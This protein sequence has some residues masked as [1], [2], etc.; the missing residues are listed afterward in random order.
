[1]GDQTNGHFSRTRNIVRRNVE[2]VGQSGPE[3]RESSVVS[4]RLIYRKK[5]MNN[6]DIFARQ[7][8]RLLSTRSNGGGDQSV[9]QIYRF[10]GLDRPAIADDPAFLVLMAVALSPE[11]ALRYSISDSRPRWTHIQ[12]YLKQHTA[13]DERESEVLARRLSRILDDYGTKRARAAAYEA[14]IRK[15]GSACAICRLQFHTIPHAVRTR[16][17]YRPLW[18][19]PEELTSPEVDH[20]KPIGWTGNNSIANMQ[21]LCRACNAAKSDGIRISVHREALIAQLPRQDVPRMHFFRLLVW[22]VFDRKGRCDR[23]GRTHGELTMRLARP[24]A[25]LTRA[26]LWLVCYACLDSD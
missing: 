11:S 20:I 21:L 25:S 9:E 15:Q 26:N 3:H 6:M 23:C 14:L 8:S 5:L 1:M 13:L 7:A 24:G 22:L 17:P 12:Y 4:R 2:G 19:S 18:E 10:L 16:D